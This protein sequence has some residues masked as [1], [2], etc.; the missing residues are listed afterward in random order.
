VLGLRIT[1]MGARSYVVRYRIRGSRAQ[2]IRTLGKIDALDLPKARERGKDWFIENVSFTAA[3]R[4]SPPSS[5]NVWSQV[6]TLIR[7]SDARPL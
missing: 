1:E 2:Y 3:A 6:V 7:T 4:R 5:P